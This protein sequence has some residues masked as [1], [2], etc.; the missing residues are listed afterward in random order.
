MKAHERLVLAQDY[1]VS[2]TS[3]VIAHEPRLRATPRKRVVYELP[4]VNESFT[5][6]VRS[7]VYATA[8]CSLTNTFYTH[9]ITSNTRTLTLHTSTSKYSYRPSVIGPAPPADPQQQVAK[10]LH[11][12]TWYC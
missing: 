12:R 3:L 10:G 2:N 11:V 8:V 5:S 4:L 1:L 6:L 9:F 7:P